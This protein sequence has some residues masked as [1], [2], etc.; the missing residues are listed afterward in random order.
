MKNKDLF[1]RTISILVK[2]YQKDTLKHG[3]CEACAVGNLVADALNTRP[4][5]ERNMFLHNEAAM[6]QKVFCSEEPM[7]QYIRPSMYSGETKR[8]IDA[9]G[10]HWVDLAKIEYAFESVIEDHE[11]KTH[12]SILRKNCEQMKK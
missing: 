1:N 8:Q 11:H 9:T 7:K 3:D 6:W 12:R 5:F 4:S 2:A 10:Y